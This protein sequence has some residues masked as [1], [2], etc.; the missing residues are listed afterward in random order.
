MAEDT[1]LQALARVARAL[2]GARVTWA[3]GA[4][5]MLRLEGIVPDFHDFDLLVTPGDADA[6]RRALLALGAQ[7]APPLPPSGTYATALFR[8]YRMCGEDFDLLCDFAVR[9]GGVA[10]R[11]PFGP[12][13]VTRS[14]PVG[15]EP[16]PLSP[17][18]DWFVL[19]LL[20]PGRAGQAETVARW[21]TAH[22][23]PQSLAWLDR[24]LDGPLPE[25]VRAQSEALRRAMDPQRR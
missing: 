15:G 18:A 7:E 9:R 6:A 2:N 20:M 3:L 19:Y 21:L 23:D 1:R 4:S 5:A 24:W 22:P 11:Y 10:Y 17:V 14:V 13:R 12:E 8:E 16:V 25:D